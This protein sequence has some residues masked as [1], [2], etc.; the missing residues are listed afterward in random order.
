MMERP[1]VRRNGRAPLIELRQVQGNNW[2][3]PSPL[4]LL[5][6]LV[7]K[8]RESGASANRGRPQMDCKVWNQALTEMAAEEMI[9]APRPNLFQPERRELR[10]TIGS[11][12][13]AVTVFRVPFRHDCTYKTSSCE[14]C[15]STFHGNTPRARNPRSLI[16]TN[17]KPQVLIN[18]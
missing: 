2:C 6:N 13:R 1:N 4:P 14:R 15:V 11:P 9:I 3:T 18:R 10:G 12:H 16:G 7:H 17:N 8:L 5:P